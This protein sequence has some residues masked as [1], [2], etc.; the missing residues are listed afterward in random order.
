[1]LPQDLLE[2]YSAGV[3]KLQREDDNI[4]EEVPQDIRQQFLPIVQRFLDLE[5]SRRASVMDLDRDW[6]L[7]TLGL[8]QQ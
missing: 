2:E 8:E 3:A 7:G 4:L 6:D 1:M 5:P